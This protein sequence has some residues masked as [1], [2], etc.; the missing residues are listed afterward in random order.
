MRNLVLL[1]HVAV[2]LLCYMADIQSGAFQAATV[3]W[4]YPRGVGSQCARVW[5]DWLNS[6]R[7]RQRW[8]QLSAPI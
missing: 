3:P 4:G 2:K 7:F 5:A 1:S 8:S 6:R